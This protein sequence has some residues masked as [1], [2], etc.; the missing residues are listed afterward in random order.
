MTTSSKTN[1]CTGG[2]S[3]VDVTEPG[4]IQEESPLASEAKDDEKAGP[5]RVQ[6]AK[7]M[8]RPEWPLDSKTSSAVSCQKSE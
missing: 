8:R 3:T 6:V 5:P 7:R 4:N 2:E 1:T